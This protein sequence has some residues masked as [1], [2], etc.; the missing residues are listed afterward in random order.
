[1]CPS[2]I[3]SVVQSI[4]TPQSKSAPESAGVMAVLKGSKAEFANLS[5]NLLLIL[6]F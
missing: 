1:M 6:A 4:S 3:T 2:L 5:G